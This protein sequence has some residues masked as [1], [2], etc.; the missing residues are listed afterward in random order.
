L[1]RLARLAF[2]RADGN[3]DRATLGFLPRRS[4]LGRVRVRHPEGLL[5]ILS[6][7]N[8]LYRGE[9]GGAPQRRAGQAYPIS[10][11]ELASRLSFFLWSEGPD[12]ELLDLAEAKR[13][14]DPAVYDAQIRRMLGDRRAESLVTNFG[15]QWLSVRTLDTIDPDEA[16]PNFDADL[17]RAFE[18][19][20]QMFLTSILLDDKR[21]VVD[22]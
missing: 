14:S 20:M 17:K 11:I 8:F 3:R 5:A 18:T 2:A 7:T 22:C 19:E 13:L 10:D 16:Y 21:S 4:R 15:F 1:S 6:S 9:P 12:S